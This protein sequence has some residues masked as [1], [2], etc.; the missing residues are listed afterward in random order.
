MHKPVHSHFNPLGRKTETCRNRTGRK[1]QRISIHS[2]ARPRPGC[3][4]IADSHDNFNP[5]GRKTETVEDGDKYYIRKISIHSVARPRR[6]PAVNA[7]DETKI[8]IHSVARPRHTN[9]W[10]WINWRAFQSTRSQDR[11]S[12]YSKAVF[13]HKNFNPLGRKTETRARQEGGKT[14]TNFNPLGR[15]TET[16]VSFSQAAT[17]AFQS[18]R[19]QDRDCEISVLISSARNF[20]PLGRKTETYLLPQF[21]LWRPISIHSVAR[22]RRGTIQVYA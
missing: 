5:L 18:T 15:K 17:R 20:N 4:R 9:I 7:D 16:K 6:I 21:L 11:D 19:S 10:R 2:V 22:P 1:D 13:I 14:L 8:S 12:K 3:R